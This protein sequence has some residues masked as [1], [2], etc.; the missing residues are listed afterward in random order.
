[1]LLKASASELRRRRYS[2]LT[3]TVTEGNSEAVSLYKTQHFL[4][5]HVF[6]AMVWEQP[7]RS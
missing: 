1:L 2:T 4:I 3:L 5:K 7:P 6:D